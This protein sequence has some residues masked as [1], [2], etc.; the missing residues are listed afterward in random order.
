MDRMQEKLSISMA[1]EGVFVYPVSPTG[2]ILLFTWDSLKTGLLNQDGTFQ[3]WL[4]VSRLRMSPDLKGGLVRAEAG[5]VMREIEAREIGAQSQEGNLVR[6]GAAEIM[7]EIEALDQED[8][9]IV[10]PKLAKPKM[11]LCT[12]SSR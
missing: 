7:G 5:E 6:V 11:S 3:F 2:R 9:F 12:K 1:P 4:Q 10:A 8:T